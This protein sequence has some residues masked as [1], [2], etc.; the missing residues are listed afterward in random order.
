MCE[1]CRVEL[2]SSELVEHVAKFHPLEE[3]EKLEQ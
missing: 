2:D 1:A 3:G